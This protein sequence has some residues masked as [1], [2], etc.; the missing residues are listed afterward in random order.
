MLMY[1]YSNLYF[2]LIKVF[3]DYFILVFNIQIL[4]IAKI[5]P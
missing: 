1:P 2:Y 5:N 3:F 4:V